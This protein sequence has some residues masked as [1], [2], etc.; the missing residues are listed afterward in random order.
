LPPSSSAAVHG[1]TTMYST[2]ITRAIEGRGAAAEQQQ[3]ATTRPPRSAASLARGLC[4]AMFSLRVRGMAAPGLLRLPHGDRPPPRSAR[5]RDPNRPSRPAPGRASASR[6]ACRSPPPPR[7][8][9]GQLPSGACMIT[10]NGSAYRSSGG[11][12]PCQT[13][14]ILGAT[15]YGRAWP[16]PGRSSSWSGSLR[17][18]AAFLIALG[19]A[20]IEV[21]DGSRAGGKMAALP[22]TAVSQVVTLDEKGR[23][24]RFARPERAEP[25]GPPVFA[26]P[27]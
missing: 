19:L 20:A 11:C 10:A 22:L 13:V 6:L 8:P 21:R 16:S 27:T 14:L 2:P 5:R 4:S 12:S 7:L 1:T 18:V 24:T 3:T 17:A 25:G 15:L 26:N 9:S 23:P